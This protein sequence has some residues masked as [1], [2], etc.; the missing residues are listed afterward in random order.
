MTRQSKVLYIVVFPFETPALPSRS[1][2]NVE[3]TNP[4]C[5]FGGPYKNAHTNSAPSPL[6]RA[7]WNYDGNGNEISMQNLTNII[8]K[9]SD[10][11]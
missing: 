10:P 6:A 1:M 9:P 5:G 2:K 7:K 4:K 8:N 11:H 3:H